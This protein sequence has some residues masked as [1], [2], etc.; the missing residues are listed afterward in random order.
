[1]QIS[2]SISR[3]KKIHCEAKSQRDMLAIS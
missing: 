1:L 2:V 3:K